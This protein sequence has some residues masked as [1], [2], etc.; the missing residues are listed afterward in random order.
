LSALALGQTLQISSGVYSILALGWLT[1]SLVCCGAALALTD[2]RHPRHTDRLVHILL[3]C[4]IIWQLRSEFRARPGM[5]LGSADLTLFKA[6]VAIL[7]LILVLAFTFRRTLAPVWFPAFLLISTLLGWWVLTASPHPA[8]DVVVVHSDA[9]DA[10]I[11]G[12]NPYGIS[13]RNIYGTGSPFYSA[14]EIEGD[15]V[16]FGYPYPPL[17][18]LLALPGALIFGDYRYGMLLALV[19]AAALIGY[20]RCDAMSKLAAILFLTTPRIFFVLEQ[21]WTEPFVVL[22][23]AATVFAGSRSPRVSAIM[24]GLLLSVKQYLLL[25]VPALWV[26]GRTLGVRPL[27]WFLAI[28]VTVAVAVTLPF[29]LWSPR[30]FVHSVVQVQLQEPFREDSLSYLSL[31]AHAGWGEWS[32]LWTVGAAMAALTF[33]LSLAKGRTAR[34]PLMLAFTY[35][36]TFAFGRKAFGN[37]YF[38]VMGALCCAIGE[39]EGPPPGLP[40]SRV[41]SS[42]AEASASAP[43]GFDAAR[44]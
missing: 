3:A 22:L 21:G 44:P 19:G 25:A 34:F 15:R 39:L 14:S 4:G 9:V 10:L 40:T 32:T 12:H 5:D 27:R 13:F 31:V 35:L 26:L 24:G 28:A 16:L 18:L 43:A 30:A 33:T 37:Y 20:G 1:V 23:M 8:I 38:L 7:A 2:S 17:S 36:G 6:G 29:F 41:S 11:H 42:R